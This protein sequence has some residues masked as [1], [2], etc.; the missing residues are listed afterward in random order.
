LVEFLLKNGAC[1]NA[2]GGKNGTTLES[3]I[4]KKIPNK[5]LVQLLLNNGAAKNLT[6]RQ[7][8]KLR[9]HLDKAID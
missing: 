9:N 2:P 6:E 8:S 1:S 3:A 5:E 7:L 4:I